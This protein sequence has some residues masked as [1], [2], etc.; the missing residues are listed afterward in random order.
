MS[1]LSQQIIQ[2]LQQQADPDKAK[3]LQ[4][5]FKTGPGEYAEGDLFLGIV[6]PKQRAIVRQFK[7][8]ITWSDIQPL[9]IHPYHEVRLTGLLLMVELFQHSFAQQQAQ[10]VKHYLAHTHYINNWDL[11]DLSA[12]KI[13]G[14]YLVDTQT[15]TTPKLLIKL[16][17]SDNLWERRIAMLASFAYIKHHHYQTTID[18]ALLLITD[19]HDLIHKAT[20]WMLREVGKQ[21][22]L[23]LEQFLQDHSQDMPRTALRYSIERLP[24][25]KR[26]FYLGKN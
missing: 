11:V 13:L 21:D 15:N 6:V 25:S 22:Q 2:H 23:V 24:E 17:E 1:Q 19:P 8:Q 12:P 18:L 3:Q 9:L 7:K 4:R 16:A 10:L 26:Q 14:Q 5:F 20:G